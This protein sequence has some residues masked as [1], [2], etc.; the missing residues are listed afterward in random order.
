MVSRG[1]VPD[2]GD[3]LELYV[4]VSVLPL[5]APTRANGGVRG[6]YQVNSMCGGGDDSFNYSSFGVGVTTRVKLNYILRNLCLEPT[7]RL[8]G[9]FYVSLHLV[10]NFLRS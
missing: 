9:G 4:C 5:G 10:R 7:R 3:V 6:V 8:V 1:R 2:L